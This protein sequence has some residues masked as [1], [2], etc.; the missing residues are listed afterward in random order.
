[1]PLSAR[2]CRSSRS[3]VAGQLAGQIVLRVLVDLVERLAQDLARLAALLGAHPEQISNEI[4]VRNDDDI[5][6]FDRFLQM[7][8]WLL[9]IMKRQK[10]NYRL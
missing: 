5:G 8:L 1:M 3:S 4:G 6:R 7:R 2:T 9:L 10:K